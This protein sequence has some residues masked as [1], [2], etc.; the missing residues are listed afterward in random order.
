MATEN[1]P[2]ADDPMFLLSHA[3]TLFPPGPSGKP[4]SV[5]T[6]R[7]WHAKGVRGVKLE[8][9]RIGGRWFVR[10]SAADAFVARCNGRPVPSPG[11]EG[12]SGSSP[13]P[14]N[15]SGNKRYQA[16]VMRRLAAKGYC[17]AEAQE[18]VLGVR[19]RR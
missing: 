4:I 9:E 14:P 15:K 8:L 5:S 13:A 16:K 17:G 18:K 6:L 7:R 2:T 3:A 19:R 12:E 1:L 10:K 11:T